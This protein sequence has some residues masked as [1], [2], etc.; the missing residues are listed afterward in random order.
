MNQPSA[1]AVW[2]NMTQAELDAAYDQAAYAANRVQVLSRYAS[3]SD[4]VRGRFG[5]SP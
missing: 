1:P 2:R 5:P 4:A 3:E